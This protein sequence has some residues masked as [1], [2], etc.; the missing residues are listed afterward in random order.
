VIFG[1][2][3]CGSHSTPASPK[4]YTVTVTGTSNQLTH[5]TTVSLTIQ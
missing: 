1:L 5:T 4:T 2:D 3:S